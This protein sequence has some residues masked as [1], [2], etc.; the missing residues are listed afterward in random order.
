M[1]LKP[2]LIYSF[3]SIK[4]KSKEELV[5]K[6]M[7]LVW[8]GRTA[9]SHWPRCQPTQELDGSW[10]TGAGRWWRV[11]PRTCLARVMH[12]GGE[13]FKEASKP[14]SLPVQGQASTRT[15]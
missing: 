5:E 3:Y 11:C 8:S 6:K 7:A 1:V 14:S 4:G 15:L 10:E 2:Q 9:A 12:K 13:G